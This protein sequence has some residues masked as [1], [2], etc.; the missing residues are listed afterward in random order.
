VP[1]TV[2]F[3]AIA[4]TGYH[5]TVT[6]TYTATDKTLRGSITFTVDP[7]APAKANVLILISDGKGHTETYKIAVTKA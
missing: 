1:E 3:T 7:S 6:K 2:A 5:A 4:D